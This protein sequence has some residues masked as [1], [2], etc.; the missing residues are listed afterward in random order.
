MLRRMMTSGERHKFLAALHVGVIA[1]VRDGRAP[2]AVPVWYGYAPG[3]DVY[4]WTRR[5][6][7]KDRLIRIAGRYSLVV[8]DE[9]P[10]YRY[11]SVEGP[12]EFDETPSISDFRRLVRRYLPVD[13][14][15]QFVEREFD[16]RGIII[17]M[18]PEH[19][20]AVNYSESP[21][22]FE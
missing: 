1:V 19:W 12:A 5:G 8:Q 20:H 14:V 13:K 6:S 21:G 18:R 15:D 10:P 16:G 22:T 4:V 2:L 17:R 7:M 3:G 9:Q 11:V